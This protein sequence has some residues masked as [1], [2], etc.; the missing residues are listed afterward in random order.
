MGKAEDGN[1]LS[2]G[3][4][5]QYRER[6]ESGQMLAGLILYRSCIGNHAYYEFM[7]TVALSTTFKSYNM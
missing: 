4:G 6:Q 1:W 7:S 2:L 5:G 3:K